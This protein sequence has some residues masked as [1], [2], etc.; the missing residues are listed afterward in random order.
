MFLNKKKITGVSFVKCPIKVT[1]IYNIIKKN[2]KIFKIFKNYKQNNLFIPSG[3][4]Y[5]SKMKHYLQK[6]TFYSKNTEAFFSK[7]YSDIDYLEDFIL[8]EMEMKKNVLQM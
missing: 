3:D 8:A 6:Q 1:N 7:I 2:L 4:I 5:I